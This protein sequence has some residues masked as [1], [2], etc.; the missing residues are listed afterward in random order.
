MGAYLYIIRDNKL[1]V[2]RTLAYKQCQQELENLLA[3]SITSLTAQNNTTFNITFLEGL[4]PQP[5]GKRYVTDISSSVSLP[6][7]SLY[8]IKVE[9]NWTGNTDYP[10][11]YVSLIA[12][13]AR[14]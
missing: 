8:E 13:R 2:Y 12:R 7:G 4:P 1:Q 5:A 9:I 14:L 3:M 11:L 10:P 6:A